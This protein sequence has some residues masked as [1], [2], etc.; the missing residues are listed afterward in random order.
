MKIT[1]EF[2]SM[3]EFRANMMPGKTEETRSPQKVEKQETG[4]LTATPEE[5]EKPP[6]VDR[7]EVRRALAELN[8]RTGK[9]IASELIHGMGFDKL[10]SIPDEKLGELMA[11]VKEVED[12]E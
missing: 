1:V 8:K 10:T 5:A 12:A 6:V 7:V 3:E 11:K 4:A 9:K 2:E